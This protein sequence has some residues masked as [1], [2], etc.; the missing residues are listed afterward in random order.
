MSL[1]TYNSVRGFNTEKL[2]QNANVRHNCRRRNTRLSTASL[3]RSLKKD[4]N[5]KFVAGPLVLKF[6]L[7]LGWNKTHKSIKN[8]K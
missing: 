4:L 1:T 2:T 5:I 7:N 6:N 8:I 3:K